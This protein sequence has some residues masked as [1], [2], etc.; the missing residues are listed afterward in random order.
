MARVAELTIAAEHCSGCLRCALACSFF[1]S[2][3]RAFNPAKSK[4]QVLPGL[5]EGQFDVVLDEG[6]THCGICVDY[7]EFGVLGKK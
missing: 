2:P 3:Q 7:C 6:C 5:E 4:I 1:T